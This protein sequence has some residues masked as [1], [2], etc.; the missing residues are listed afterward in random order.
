MDWDNLT[1]IA[2]SD[3]IYVLL[4]LPLV[5]LS[6]LFLN[7]CILS[8]G[9]RE[10][11]L[12]S[13]LCLGMLPATL[14]RREKR[15]GTHTSGLC[16]WSLT[17]MRWGIHIS[18]RDLAGPTKCVIYLK[19]DTK[20]C[21]KRLKKYFSTRICQLMWKRSSSSYMRAMV[22]LWE[23][24]WLF[25]L[26]VWNIEGFTGNSNLSIFNIWHFFRKFI[27]LWSSLCFSYFQWSLSL[28]MKSQRQAGGSLR[29]SSR[30]SSS[31]PMRDL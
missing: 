3:S 28:H 17:E 25:T 27:I 10:W 18:K 14:E 7:F 6:C 29:S 16:M 12:W 13:L 19:N 15:M 11:L 20:C 8:V 1:K 30:S 4:Y 24:R 5:P 31:I 21:L 22:T 2:W 9:C 26:Q 23:V